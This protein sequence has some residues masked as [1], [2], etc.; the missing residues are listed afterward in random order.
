MTAHH[1]VRFATGFVFSLV[2]LLTGTSSS[3]NGELLY[4]GPLAVRIACGS[5][6]DTI[7]NET[8]F[9]WSKDFGY[10]GGTSGP[11]TTPSR[12]AAQL[13]TVRFFTISDGQ[14]NCYN[15]SIPSGH[16]LTRFMELFPEL[17][18]LKGFT[19]LCLRQACA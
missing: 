4:S 15:I 3:D 9:L 11:L 17:I 2:G 13:N 12:I 10:T 16:Y 14:E 18:A 19:A 1:V 5:T 6:V 8:G 7:A